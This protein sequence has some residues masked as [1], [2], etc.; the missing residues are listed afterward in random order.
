MLGILSGAAVLWLLWGTATQLFENRRAGVPP[1]AV[2]SAVEPL[3]VP[4]PADVWIIR[5]RRLA[6][7]GRLREALTA[8]E[9]I[10]PGDARRAQA[11]ELRATIQR[12]LLESSRGTGPSGTTT[13]GDAAR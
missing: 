1:P 10:G 3:P 11:D 6:D 4:A 8:L 7:S 2:P 12:R 13:A 5:A 9:E